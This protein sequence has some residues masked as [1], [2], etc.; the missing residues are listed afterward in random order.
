MKISICIESVFYNMDFIEG[1]RAMH[2]AGVT[3]FEFWNWWDKDLQ[4]IKAEKERLGL[5]TTAFCT[6]HISLVDNSAR[7][8]YIEGLKESIGAAKLLGCKNLITQTGNDT[9]YP[10]RQQH[11]NMVSCLK[12]CSSILEEAGITLLVEPLNLYV[13]TPGYYLYSSFEAFDVIDEV[14][15]R[16]VR[17][18]FDIYHQQIMEGNL[19]RNITNGI[20]RIGHI[21][22]AGNPGGNELYFGEINYPEVF[23]AVD[24]AGYNGFVGFE[25]VPLE[26][27]LKGIKAFTRPQE[28]SLHS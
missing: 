10:R 20:D 16:N 2:S 14:G 26:D 5:E 25:Y 17:V 9:G 27:P 8:K 7:E 22:A 6:R 1:M 4:A 23:K 24:A 21:H 12:A 19:I 3:A 11:R 13:D 28:D 15:S 18:L